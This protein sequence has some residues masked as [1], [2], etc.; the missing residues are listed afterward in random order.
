VN[1]KDERCK[2]HFEE[3]FKMA[4]QKHVFWWLLTIIN[5]NSDSFL[6]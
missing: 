2:L 5:Y 4:E 3:K 6:Y 1:R